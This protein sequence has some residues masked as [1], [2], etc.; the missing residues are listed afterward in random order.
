MGVDLVGS[1]GNEGG[2]MGRAQS[3]GVGS[4]ERQGV[5]TCAVVPCVVEAE[6]GKERSI[7]F[8]HLISNEN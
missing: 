7:S 6:R 4:I 2:G 5:L 8:K 3:A 1:I